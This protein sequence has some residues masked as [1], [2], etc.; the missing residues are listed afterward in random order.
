MVENIKDTSLTDLSIQHPVKVQKVQN[1]DSLIDH[2]ELTGILFLGVKGDIDVK[3]SNS[4]S[5]LDVLA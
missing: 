3:V 4:E 2:K 1:P 5:K